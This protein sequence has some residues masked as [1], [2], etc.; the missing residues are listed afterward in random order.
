MKKKE[1]NICK[2]INLMQQQNSIKTIRKQPIKKK[3]CTQEPKEK[4]LLH[5][6]HNR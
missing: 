1:K 6:R 2:R 4:T 5:Y 3:F